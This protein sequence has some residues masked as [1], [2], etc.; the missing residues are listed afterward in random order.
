M[1]ATALVSQYSMVSPFQRYKAHLLYPAITGSHEPPGIYDVS[2]T[3][4]FSFCRSICDTGGSLVHGVV[5]PVAGFRLERVQAVVHSLGRIVG[6][7]DDLSR[8]SSSRLTGLPYFNAPIWDQLDKSQLHV[9]DA[10]RSHF[11][12]R[13][14]GQD[15][16]SVNM[17]HS[18]HGC[19]REHVENICRNGIVAVKATDAGYFGSGCYSTLNVEYAAR[20]ARGE[21]DSPPTQRPSP[22]GCYPVIMFA[23][24]VGMAYPVTP[25]DYGNVAGIVAGSSDFFGRPLKPGFDCH[26]ACVNQSSGFQAVSRADCQYV[27][28]VI[29]QKIQMLPVAVLW[30][31]R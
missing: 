23:C 8:S 15:P 12:E 19:R 2:S 9:L 16:R 6:Y 20:Y 30:F 27:E 26:V 22:D 10:L 13:P 31:Q 14:P 3:S 4:L 5:N 25:I 17:F 28:V 29:E 18:F 24:F 11:L 21:F 1:K 7:E